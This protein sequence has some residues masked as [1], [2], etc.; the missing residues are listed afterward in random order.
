MLISSRN[1]IGTLLYDLSEF[2]LL[3][4][5]IKASANVNVSV[6][7]TPSIIETVTVILLGNLSVR[8]FSELILGSRDSD[9][10][11]VFQDDPGERRTIL[12]DHQILT[13][14]ERI[15]LMENM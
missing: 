8:K 12:H 6:I 15:F 2:L 11:P 5:N 10:Y 7:W 4:L 3:L 1:L 9:Y 13:V 14:K